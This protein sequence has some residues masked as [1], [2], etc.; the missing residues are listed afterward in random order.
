MDGCKNSF[1]EWVSIPPKVQCRCFDEY[2]KLPWNNELVRL[3]ASI[4]ELIGDPKAKA[5]IIF[6]YANES[7]KVSVFNR[8]KKILRYLESRKILSNRILF[9]FEKD[10][11]NLTRIRIL[12][13]GAELPE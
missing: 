7:E 8:Q 13:E 11:G 2:G 5:Y 1:S 3:E 4:I 6:S 10:Y 9:K 12:P